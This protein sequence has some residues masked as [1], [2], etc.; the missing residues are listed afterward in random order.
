LRV[1]KEVYWNVEGRG[2][3]AGKHCDELRKVE[4]LQRCMQGDDSKDNNSS[5]QVATE[6]ADDDDSQIANKHFAPGEEG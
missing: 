1:R 2:N 6:D 4:D 5:G 3:E